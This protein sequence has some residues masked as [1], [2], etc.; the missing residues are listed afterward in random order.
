MLM[1]SDIMLS[2]ANKTIILCVIMECHYA[3]SC[4]VPRIG[5]ATHLVTVLNYLRIMRLRSI[6]HGRHDTQHNDT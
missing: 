3:E 4:G 1:T 6:L 2:V 5:A